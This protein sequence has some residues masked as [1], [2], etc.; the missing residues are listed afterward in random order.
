MSKSFAH[1]VYIYDV[2]I[3][4][5]LKTW[6]IT[7]NLWRT[8]TVSVG[9]M[10]LW[11][12]KQSVKSFYHEFQPA[13]R[14]LLQSHNYILFVGNRQMGNSCLTLLSIV[15]HGQVPKR[16]READLDHTTPK[17][18]SNPVLFFSSLLC[19]AVWNPAGN[20]TSSLHLF[21]FNFVWF[22]IDS[23]KPSLKSYSWCHLP[24]WLPTK[25]PSKCSKV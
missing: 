16:L 18:G 3:M 15:M 7:V 11:S 8:T 13:I 1:P 20:R 22:S 9:N 10:N 25:N 5:V 19:N 12:S 24:S 17:S 23:P 21:I 4:L 6:L 14:S 2:F